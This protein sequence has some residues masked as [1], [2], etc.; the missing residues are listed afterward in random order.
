MQFEQEPKKS[1]WYIYAAVGVAY[2]ICI[3]VY[4]VIVHKATEDGAQNIAPVDKDEDENTSANKILQSF[5]D[6]VNSVMAK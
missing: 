4:S 2:L 1:F 5:A 3:I 6:F